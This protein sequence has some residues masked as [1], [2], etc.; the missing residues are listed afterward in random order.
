M[1]RLSSSSPVTARMMSGGRAMPA[2]SSVL[3]SVA[4][5]SIATC[6]NSTSSWSKR[7]RRC[8]ISVTSCPMSTSERATFFP[9]FPPPAMI[10]YTRFSPCLCRAGRLE[11]A[12]VA[13]AHRVRQHGDRSLRRADGA[14]AAPR[15]EVRAQRIEHPYDGA[16]D[17][18]ALLQHLPDD[19]IRV[20]AV[21]GNDSGI[22]L[23]DAGAAKD[24][25]VHAVADDEAASPAAETVERLLLLVDAR[26]APTLRRELHGDCRADSAP[27]H[28]N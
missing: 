9:T 22:R 21:G 16:A 8:S 25:T 27:S 6:P 23:R 28:D 5:P 7:S 11:R 10:A 1:I 4:S 18:V 26:D 13:R 2:R 15:V 17:A 14:Q 12:H 20:V 24:V 3:I 19:D